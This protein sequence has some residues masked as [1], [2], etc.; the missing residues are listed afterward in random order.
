M[1]R[2]SSR[3][4]GRKK[5]GIRLKSEVE[6]QQL[7]QAPVPCSDEDERDE[8]EVNGEYQGAGGEE[9]DETKSESDD[10]RVGY[11]ST[12]LG[13]LSMILLKRTIVQYKTP[14]LWVS[15]GQ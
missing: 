8:Q 4:L 6:G 2:G 13:D 14:N 10:Q 11:R 12:V 3:V 15:S 9:M 5:G 7:E 1:R